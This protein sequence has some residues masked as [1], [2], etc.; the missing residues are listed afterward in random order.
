MNKHADDER[1]RR[2]F[3]KRISLASLL[4]GSGLFGS[5]LTG[6]ST[7]SDSARSDTTESGLPGA[8]GMLMGM[9]ALRGLAAARDCRSRRVSSYD[10]TGRNEDSMRVPAGQ[11]VTLANISGAGCITHIWMTTGHM[12]SDYLRKL[13]LRAY[14]DGEEQ[15]S[16]EAPL[17]DFFCLGHG[18][19]EAFQSLPFNV[20]TGSQIKEL[21]LAGLNCYFPMPFSEGAQITIT[22]DGSGEVP[23]LYFYIDYEEY[24][25]LA[26]NLLRFHAQWR[27]VYPTPGSVNLARP[28]MT[29]ETTNGLVNLDGKNNYVILEARGRG[30]FVGCNLSTDN[31][32]PIRQVDWFGEGDDM[33]YI[34][35]EETPSIIGTGTED[36]FSAAWGYPSGVYSG[37]YH[38]VTLARPS[39]PTKTYSGKWTTYRFHIED[40]IA[41]SSSI[42]VTIEHGHANVHSND[43]ASTAYWYQTEPHAP[44]PPLPKVNDR[45]PLSDEES[46]RL[47]HR[48]F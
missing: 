20:V 2:R 36:Y 19:V 27:R 46:N 38:G 34:D 31:V 37:L 4:A 26:P 8:Q 6:C 14:W 10:R 43:Y 9:G 3:L 23:N 25:T 5:A 13:V 15:P 33:I 30:H 28:D 12:E 48:T 41:F 16:I 44:F 47:F 17:G 18:R 45:L 7:T 1:P 32:N 24:K 39:D 21:N 22:N 29:R 40:P 42:R 11:S 35:G